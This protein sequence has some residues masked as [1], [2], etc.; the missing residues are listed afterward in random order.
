MDIIENIATRISEV[1]MR[2]PKPHLE[3]LEIVR[4]RVNG[5]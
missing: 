4:N 2:K 1:N 3:V 5:Y